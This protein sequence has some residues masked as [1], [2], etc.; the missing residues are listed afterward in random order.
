MDEV[1]KALLLLNKAGLD[2]RAWEKIIAKKMSPEM[3]WK[4]SIEK[5]KELGFT[6]SALTKIR[7]DEKRGWAEREIEKR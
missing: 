3:L 6:E 7:E 4:S 2:V 1:L 5:V